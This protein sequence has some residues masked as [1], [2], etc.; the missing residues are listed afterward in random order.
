MSCAR[1]QVM[2]RN[3]KLVHHLDAQSTKGKTLMKTQ[4]N[5]KVERMA[6]SKIHYSVCLPTAK[7]Q[8]I[9]IDCETKREQLTVK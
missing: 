4:Y 2:G 5:I 8:V 7:T 3:H 9:A 6:V 1:D